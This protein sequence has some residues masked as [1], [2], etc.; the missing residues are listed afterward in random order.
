ML[1]LSTKRKSSDWWQLQTTVEEFQTSEA[2]YRI[3]D[4]IW[5]GSEIRK[6]TV[7]YKR[8]YPKSRTQKSQWQSEKLKWAKWIKL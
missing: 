1:S 6:F 8:Q 3:E 4:F 7:S 2:P 5:R